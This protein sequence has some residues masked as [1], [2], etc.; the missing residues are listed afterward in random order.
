MPAN[1]TY[2]ARRMQLKKQITEAAM[3]NDSKK[4]Q[5]LRAE[6]EKIQEKLNQ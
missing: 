6:L 3:S 2:L 1:H 4:E 5:R